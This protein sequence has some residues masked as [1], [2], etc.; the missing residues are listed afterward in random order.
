MYCATG[1][2]AARRARDPAR[3]RGS[4]VRGERPHQPV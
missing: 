2:R 3:R 1:Q 4:R